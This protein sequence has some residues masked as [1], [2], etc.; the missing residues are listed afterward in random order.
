M[1]HDRTHILITGDDAPVFLQN[2]L[3]C[4][5][6]KASADTP[7]YGLLL[8][9]QGRVLAEMFVIAA[10][11]GFLID[12]D[13]ANSENLLRRLNMYKL[14]SKV[15]FTP[16]QTDFKG[17]PDPRAPNLVLGQGDDALIA[18][19]VPPVSAMRFDKDFPADLNLDL[20]GA[21]DWDKGCFV[22]QELAARMHHR[23]LAKKRLLTV[24]GADLKPEADLLN[25]S[26]VHM[27]ILRCVNGT[28]TQ[29]LALLKLESLQTGLLDV[30]V[31]T[32]SY[33]SVQNS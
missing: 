13:K 26:G 20:L 19:G 15:D 12:T 7:L 17:L 33:L 1:T 9:P 21:I 24:E 30:K 22:G 5:M 3:T 16:A 27:G 2:L 6:R 14:R 10:P 29:G 32:P 4:D 23:G 28:G 31:N 8:G 11:G 18:H 25:P